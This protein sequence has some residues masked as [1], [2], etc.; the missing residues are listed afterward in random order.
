MK[1][2]VINLANKLSLFSD[3]WSPKIIAQVNDHQFKLV[4]FAGEF[5]W[6][7]HEGT[8]EVF[9]VLEGGLT[10]DFRDGAAVL[11]PGEMIVIPKGVEHRPRAQKEC[12]VMLVEHA[13]TVNTG[14]AESDLTAPNDEWI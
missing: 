9:I 12:R 5:V 7:A 10:I 6:H 13:G 2:D 11:G 1:P 8:D 4:K 14:D 3:H